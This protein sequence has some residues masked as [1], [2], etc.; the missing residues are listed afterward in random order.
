MPGI[1]NQLKKQKAAPEDWDRWQ[2]EPTEENFQTVLQ[3]LKPTIDSALFS[4]GQ[5]DESLRLQ[6][7]IMA[8]K[9]LR[10]YDP[11]KNVLLKTHV[12]NNL[13][14]LQRV[15]AERGRMIHVPE[16][17]LLD[18]HNIARYKQD[19][20]EKFGAD[21]SLAQ[22]RDDLGISSKRV[23]LA[24]GVM[25]ESMETASEKGDV[26]VAP[27]NANDVWLDYVYH[28]QDE[29]GRKILE[30]TTGYNGRERLKKTE[31]ARRLKISPAA[32]S[33]RISSILRKLEEGTHYDE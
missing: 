32:V 8:T 10:S 26:L 22:I 30:W 13:K 23:M 11:K 7:N 33:K 15:R 27:Q 3:G 18:Q 5:G 17:R 20:R 31:I 16:S 2:K 25:L 14:G 4:F 6:A 1:L 9:A 29:I 28:D 12:Y 21:P 24:E 19:Y